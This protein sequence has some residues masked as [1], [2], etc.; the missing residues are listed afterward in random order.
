MG[1]AIE[2]VKTDS[3]EMNYFRTGEGKQSLVIIPGLSIQSVMGAAEQIRQIY[4][5]YLNVFTVY[6]MD[7]RVDLPAEYPVREMARDTADA[8]KALGLSD[9]CI[10]GASQGGMIALEIAIKHPEL[11]KKV[12]VGSTS[13]NLREKDS[14]AIAEW[15][16]YAKEKDKKAL[17]LAYGKKIYPPAVFE[18]F[19]DALA[20]A[21][22]TVTDEDLE[23][24]II[25]AEGLK[26][27]DIA[28]RLKEIRCPVLVTGEFKDEV[29]DS[30]MTMEIAQELDEKDG[31]ELYMYNGFGHAAF[32][33]APDYRERLCGFF[34]KD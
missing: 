28:D 34:L 23:R 12:A 21:A 16:S 11:V 14:E 29:L 24:F 32:D 26:D 19:K 2:T 31:F 18:Q 3:F 27:F 17:Y 30:D 10:F 13:S 15:I 5:P 9:I 8:I 4:E 1:I 7:R 22:D 33:T 20:A 25:C 6:V